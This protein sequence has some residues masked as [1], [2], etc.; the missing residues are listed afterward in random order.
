MTPAIEVAHRLLDLARADRDAFDWL[1]QGV[2]LRP[3]TVFFSAQQAVEKALKAVM[4]ARNMVPPRTHDLLALAA[5]LNAAGI[6]TPSTPDEMAILNPYAVT[7]RYD[8]EDLNLAT[9]EQ[10]RAMMNDIL[11][12][13]ARM[14]DQVETASP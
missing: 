12:W 6:P 11:G 8:D 14:I 3:A 4:T 5:E 13:A 10:V 1:A 2:G 9:H 7:F